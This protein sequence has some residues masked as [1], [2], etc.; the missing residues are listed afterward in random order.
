MYWIT[1]PKR[2]VEVLTFSTC[3]CDFFGSRAFT[4]RIMSRRSHTRLRQT[5]NPVPNILNLVSG[6]GDLETQRSTPSEDGHVKR[7]VEIG[8]IV[9]LSQGR[10][11]IAS[12]LQKLESKKALP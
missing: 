4:Y 7:E 9:A 10:P 11:S 3:E 5:L 1:L 12:N 2:F 6:E 8:S